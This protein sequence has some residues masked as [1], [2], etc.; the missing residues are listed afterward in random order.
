[1]T[2]TSALSDTPEAPEPSHLGEMTIRVRKDELDSEELPSEAP[3]STRPARRRWLPV[4]LA[5]T[6]GLATVVGFGIGSRMQGVEA[7]PAEATASPVA[8]WSATPRSTPR[9]AP[10]ASPPTGPSA[11]AVPEHSL[12][13]LE[14]EL[15]AQVEPLQQRL[16]QDPEDLVTRKRL[17][18]LLVRNDQLMMAYDQASGILRRKPDDPDGLYVH[19]VV[20]L[21]MGHTL[22]ALRLLDRVVTQV[23][24]HVLAHEARAEAQRR[25]GDAQGA[26]ES[27]QRARRSVRATGPAMEELIAAASEGRLAEHLGAG[28]TTDVPEGEGG[29]P[30]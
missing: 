10:G 7:T 22:Q 4:L 1:M 2:T 28:E 3:R 23:P 6:A 19:G 16:A 24:D 14:P 13:P 26:T 27:A 11:T 25:I 29:A 30:W 9:A 5:Y 15:R 17:A 8:P 18:V 12:A 20:R 21:A